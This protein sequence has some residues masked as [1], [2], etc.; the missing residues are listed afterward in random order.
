MSRTPVTPSVLYFQDYGNRTQVISPFTQQAKSANDDDLKFATRFGIARYAQNSND[1]AN[2]LRNPA[3]QLK[4]VNQKLGDITSTLNTSYKNYVASLRTLY[5]PEE[6][7]FA[8]ADAYIRPLLAAEMDILKLNYPYAIGGEA[9]GQYNP[10][11][12]LAQGLGASSGGYEAST[13]FQNWRSLKK[14][15][16]AR[17]KHRKAKKARSK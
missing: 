4:L 11:I 1:L 3:D 17:K 8:R 12:G 15:F 5:L 2:A 16:K 14:A 7:I 6:E 9:G 13:Q 10:L